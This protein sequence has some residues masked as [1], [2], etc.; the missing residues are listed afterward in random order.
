MFDIDM[1]H[2]FIAKETFKTAYVTQKIMFLNILSTDQTIHNKILSKVCCDVFMFGIRNTHTEKKSSFSKKND[3][4]AIV[5]IEMA[6]V[7]LLPCI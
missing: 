4:M 6:L 3:T 2:L 7:L 1:K 5:Y